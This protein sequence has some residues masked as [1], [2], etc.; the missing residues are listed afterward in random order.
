MA[1]FKLPNKFNNNRTYITKETYIVKGPKL[2]NG[3]QQYNYMFQDIVADVIEVTPQDLKNREISV[4]QGGFIM[5]S[6][7]CGEFNESE[8]MW[9][10]QQ[11]LHAIHP[12]LKEEAKAFIQS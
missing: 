6:I 12:S 1:K 11:I 7:E 4:P 8:M 10:M 9:F 5:K 2:E 3:T